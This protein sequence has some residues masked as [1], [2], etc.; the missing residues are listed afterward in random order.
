MIKIKKGHAWAVYEN[1]R[2]FKNDCTSNCTKIV[3][4]IGRIAIR[5]VTPISKG[6]QNSKKSTNTV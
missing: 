3:N 5:A 1:I 2:Y 6:T 4:D